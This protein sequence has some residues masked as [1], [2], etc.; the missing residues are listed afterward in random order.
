[1]FNKIVVKGSKTNPVSPPRVVPPAKSPSPAPS[2]LRAR[3]VSPTNEE[4]IVELQNEYAQF[5]SALSPGRKQKRE[6]LVKAVLAK[7]DIFGDLQPRHFALLLAIAPERTSDAIAAHMKNNVKLFSAMITDSVVKPFAMIQN[8]TEFQ[9]LIYQWTQEDFLKNELYRIPEVMQWMY[10]GNHLKQQ[11]WSEVVKVL[12]KGDCWKLLAVQGGVGPTLW[13][14]LCQF[15]G[16]NKE[17]RDLCL[18]DEQF[19][20]E[21]LQHLSLEQRIALFNMADSALMERIFNC[22]AQQRKNR[23]VL[24]SVLNHCF[25][26]IRNGCF[27]SELVKENNAEFLEYV[28]DVAA[29]ED[30]ESFVTQHQGQA[31]C[32]AENFKKKNE[33][34]A[35]DDL[36]SIK[37]RARISRY[38]EAIIND[39]VSSKRVD[40]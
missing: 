14:K 36:F 15:L 1:M 35:E 18:S 23:H 9:S 24:Y 17:G 7:P 2:P 20:S 13:E 37:D 29:P 5:S 31:W 39:E 27:Y 12:G 34:P 4:C 10:Q 8:C 38:L 40:D 6:S 33:K 19:L 25:R 30:L 22:C 28:V 21:Y 32:S 11:H 16:E 3:S 26:E